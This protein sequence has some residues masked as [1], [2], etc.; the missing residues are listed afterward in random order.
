MQ[1]KG[2]GC[3][4][5]IGVGGSSKDEGAKIWGQLVVGLFRNFKNRI[6]GGWLSLFGSTHEVSYDLEGYEVLEEFEV[7]EIM[8]SHYNAERNKVLYLI[9][10]KVY[11]EEFE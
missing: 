5:L 3:E 10:L 2:A 7:E 8:G 11:P 6:S 9:K 1:K 4:N